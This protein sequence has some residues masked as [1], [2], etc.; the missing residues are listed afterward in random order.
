[1]QASHIV[2]TSIFTSQHYQQDHTFLLFE[3]LLLIVATREHN[4]LIVPTPVSIFFDASLGVYTFYNRFFRYSF[5]CWSSPR[6]LSSRS[7]CR[8]EW[9]LGKSKIIK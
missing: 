5:R 4:L 3:F 9:D 1:M 6:D 8:L 2:P 7:S